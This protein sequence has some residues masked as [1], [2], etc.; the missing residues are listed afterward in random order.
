MEKDY[1]REVINNFPYPIASCFT[2]LH[3]P[4]YRNVGYKRLKHIFTIAERISRYLASIVIS[5]CREHMEAHPELTGQCPISL[6]QHIKRPSWGHWVHFGRDGLK[7]LYQQQADI[8]IP[9][10][11]GFWFNENVKPKTPAAKALTEL[12]RIRNKK[13]G[14]TFNDLSDRE[15]QE[16]CEETWE[17][18]KIILE[19]LAFLPQYELRFMHKIVV[20]HFRKQPITYLHD[21]STGYGAHDDFEGDEEHQAKPMESEAALLL[22]QKHVVILILSH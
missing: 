9:E 1:K 12:V 11:Y 7:W 18:L 14:H 19:A 8:V 5:E 2:R 6:T 4:K 10:L 17:K 22:T 21:Y 15:Y 3:T 13:L 20:R 16:L